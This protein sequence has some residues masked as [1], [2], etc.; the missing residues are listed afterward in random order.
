MIRT[1]FLQAWLH[2]LVKARAK[3]EQLDI[4]MFFQGTIILNHDYNSILKVRKDNGLKRSQGALSDILLS[5]SPIPS[6][7]DIEPTARDGHAPYSCWFFHAYCAAAASKISWQKVNHA[8]SN[9]AALYLKVS[10]IK[11]ELCATKE[12]SRFQSI[13]QHYFRPKY[14]LK[15][16]CEYCN[17]YRNE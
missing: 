16:P 5:R 2:W 6:S 17:V 4:W 13:T 12:L 3:S 7:W 10:F 15:H 14:C 1:I 9:I 11:D 8:I